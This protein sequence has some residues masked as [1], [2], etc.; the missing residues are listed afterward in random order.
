M[1]DPTQSRLARMLRGE[2]PEEERQ[3]LEA[4]FL[5]DDAFFQELAREEEEL[6]EAWEQGDLDGPTSQAVEHL[7]HTST[8][9]Q[10]LVDMTHSLDDTVGRMRPREEDSHSGPLRSVLA[11]GR[12]PR[13][14]WGVAVALALALAAVL[15]LQYRMVRLLD[16]RMDDLGE[17]STPSIDGGGESPAGAV[18]PG[19]SPVL[20]LD[21]ASADRQLTV[22]FSRTSG[23]TVD[24]R[25]ER[26]L[27]PGS[28]FLELEEISEGR[29]ANRVDLSLERSVFPGNPLQVVLP[30]ASLA[31]GGYRLRL[32]E[33]SQ[34]T[35][36]TWSLQL[37]E[38]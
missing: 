27:L 26:T 19:S 17:G 1:S 35:I 21:A 28:Y 11:D 14:L 25:L 30:G 16:Q 34:Q 24:I 22:R 33:G 4:R 20:V 12:L 32:F 5:E 38:E 6:L 10:T 7:V 15:L 13:I 18:S 31:A 23:L 29:I 36:A 9:V 2:L 3:S 8:R 37:V